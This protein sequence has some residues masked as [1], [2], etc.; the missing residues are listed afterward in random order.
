MLFVIQRVRNGSKQLNSGF[1]SI[2][3]YGFVLARRVHL[4]EY[5]PLYDVMMYVSDPT[6][7]VKIDT[8]EILSRWH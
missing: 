4:A 1:T 3:S 8:I 7:H 2:I 6:M 5:P